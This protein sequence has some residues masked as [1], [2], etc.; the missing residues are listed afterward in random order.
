MNG[1]CRITASLKCINGLISSLEYNVKTRKTDFVIISNNDQIK[2]QYLG[3]KIPAEEYVKFLKRTAFFQ[4]AI[5]RNQIVGL[6][7]FIIIS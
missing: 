2:C 5:K 1:R 4:L 3:D 7:D 6:V